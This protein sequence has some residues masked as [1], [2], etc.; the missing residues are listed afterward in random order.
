M[1]SLKRRPSSS[2]KK[3]FKILSPRG[4]RT[5][6]AD[7]PSGSFLGGGPG[8]GGVEDM[9]KENLKRMREIQ[10]NHEEEKKTMQS[11]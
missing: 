9:L 4:N 5:G 10:I 1:S 11:K 8:A 2:T 6:P 7:F 3:F